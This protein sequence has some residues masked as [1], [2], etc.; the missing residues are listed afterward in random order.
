MLRDEGAAAV[1]AVNAD[2]RRTGNKVRVTLWCERANPTRSTWRQTILD[3]YG[4]YFEDAERAEAEARRA[5]ATI[6]IPVVQLDG[7]PL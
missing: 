7:G 5:L 6:G 1:S 2:V 4:G 3:T